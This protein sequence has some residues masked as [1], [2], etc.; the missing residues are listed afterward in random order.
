MNNDPKGISGRLGKC[1]EMVWDGAGGDG[2]AGEGVRT[3]KNLPLVGRGNCEGGGGQEVGAPWLKHR[4][5]SAH[6]HT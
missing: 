6:G 5:G 1:G 4:A 2:R 3:S